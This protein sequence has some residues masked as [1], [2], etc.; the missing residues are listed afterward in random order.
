[1]STRIDGE[2][3][4]LTRYDYPTVEVSIVEDTNPE[5]D[6]P[7]RLEMTQW[8][9]GRQ[10]DVWVPLGALRVFANAITAL[11]DKHAAK[12]VK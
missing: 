7:V 10:C 12:E 8:W 1:M 3:L 2:L 4:D 11:A 6:V 5:C 9:A